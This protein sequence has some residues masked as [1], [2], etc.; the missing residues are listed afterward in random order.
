M[1]TT[2]ASSNTIDLRNSSSF[3]P[4]VN[5]PNEW[6]LI[7]ILWPFISLVGLA[8]NVTFIWTVIKVSALHTSTFIVLAA[9]SCSDILSLIGRLV[10]S[11]HNFLTSPLRS[12][13]DITAIISDTIIWFCF[14]LSTWLVTLVSVERF[15]AICHPIKYRVLKGTKR[16]LAVICILIFG[17]TC[18]AFLGI[19]FSF[20]FE[21][22]CI[23]WPVAA[24]FS[25]YPSNIELQ[26]IAYLPE[27][28]DPYFLFYNV[29]F[30]MCTVG[31]LFINCY[32]YMGT[33]NVLIKR[34]RNRALQTSAQ[35][36]RNIHQLSIMVIANGVVYFV[37]VF[38]FVLRVAW[39]VSTML[40]MRY[41]NMYE[42]IVLMDTTY[43]FMLINASVN[44]LVYF[45]SN[46]S[47][48]QHFQ[49][50]ILGGFCKPF[51]I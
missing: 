36:E 48:R 27:N 12:G 6:I 46:Q 42:N 37:C 4:L 39:Q 23:R 1:N 40:G 35:L 10:H 45:I 14:I 33:I 49:K 17:S 22:Y 15:L 5:L 44:P 2:C 29:I 51:Q 26:K 7:I 11:L 43:T 41:L 30:L 21:H 32:M 13:N 34:K 50:T 38:V 25:K 31:L 28:L 47:Y 18:I 16:M 9:L 19:P 3:L 20:A 24:Q 8:G